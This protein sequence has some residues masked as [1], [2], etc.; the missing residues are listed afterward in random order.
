M[1]YLLVIETLAVKDLS[2]HSWGGGI[3]WFPLPC[4]GSF[5]KVINQQAYINPQKKEILPVLSCLLRAASLLQVHVSKFQK[6]PGFL[7]V[8]PVY[9]VNIHNF[10]PV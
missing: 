6:Q 1:A 10:N 4:L 7:G 8:F 3:P 9:S 2:W 5:A